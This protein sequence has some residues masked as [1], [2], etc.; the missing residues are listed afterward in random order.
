MDDAL[1]H[2]EEIQH[3]ELQTESFS[4]GDHFKS[5]RKLF[6]DKYHKRRRGKL[7]FCLLNFMQVVCIFKFV[8][9]TFKSLHKY[10]V[11]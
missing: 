5:D 10:K 1:K 6:I 11:D 4:N 2:M 9:Y 3:I 8:Y 7:I